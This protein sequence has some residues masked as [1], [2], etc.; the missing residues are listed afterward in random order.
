MLSGGISVNSNSSQY[1]TNLFDIRVISYNILAD[2]YA[3]SDF[4]I[5]H[6]YPYCHPDHLET[7]YRMQLILQELIAYAADVICLQE[8]DRKSYN[9]YFM[10]LLDHMGYHQSS[11]SCKEGSVSEG[12]AI[13]IRTS[14]T[15]I[16]CLK[17]ID[18]SMRKY[19]NESTT[20]CPNLVGLFSA[21]NDIHELLTLK[22]GTIAQ[23]AVI[24]VNGHDENTSSCCSSSSSETSQNTSIVIISNTHMFF[25]PTAAFVRLL[26]CDAILRVLSNLTNHINFNIP[27]ASFNPYE[28]SSDLIALSSSQKILKRPRVTPIFIGDLNSTTETAVIEYLE[29]LV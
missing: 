1:S 8:C 7:E 25:H 18:F 20:T 21:R 5:S 29:R 16:R 28:T 9:Q 12:C 11:H 26:Q 27:L 22:L 6:L 3:T 19:F 13:F 24:E 17:F 10:P 4:A 23:I 14:N 2:A 15:S